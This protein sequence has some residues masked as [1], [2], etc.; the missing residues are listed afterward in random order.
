MLEG[1]AV[2]AQR[3]QEVALLVFDVLAA[4]G[5]QLGASARHGGSLLPLALAACMH[6][7]LK[8]GFPAVQH[9]VLAHRVIPR[10]SGCGI[11]C[12]HATGNQATGGRNT[13]PAPG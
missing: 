5:P 10:S 9:V 4:A 6:P 13:M 7:L 12:M 2:A 3:Q 8:A 1:D 11:A